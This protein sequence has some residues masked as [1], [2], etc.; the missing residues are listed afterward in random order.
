MFKIV[1]QMKATNRDVVGDKCFKNDNGELV[2]TDDEKHLAWKEYYQRLLNEEFPWDRV[3]LV[4]DKPTI[5]P[6]PQ[7]EKESVRTA[8]NKMKKGKA[9]GISGAVTEMLLA[10]G[11]AGIERMTNLFNRIVDEKE[12]PA[13]WNTSVIV[14]C[15]KNKGEATDRGNYRGLKLLGNMMK[16]FERVIEQEIR[17]V[18]DIDE[19][20][21]GFMPGRGTIDAIFIARQLQEKYL[22]KKRKSS[23]LPL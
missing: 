4:Y 17:R 20:Q 15:F 18:V 11:E 8:L 5:G 16:V 22:G 6:R 9:S 21:F 14:N 10:T 3:D 7:I 23:I 19:M 2:F 12:I 13:E 1:K